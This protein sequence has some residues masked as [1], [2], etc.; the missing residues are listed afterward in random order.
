M[1]GF[2]IGMGCGAVIGAA[3]MLFVSLMTV[4]PKL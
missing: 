1:I 3:A 4:V 2:F